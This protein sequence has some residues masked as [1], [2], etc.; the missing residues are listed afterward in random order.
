MSSR[1]EIH[2]VKDDNRPRSRFLSRRVGGGGGALMRT[3]KREQTRVGENLKFKFS[4]MAK[5]AF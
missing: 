4:E 2:R 5:N 3:S 1:N